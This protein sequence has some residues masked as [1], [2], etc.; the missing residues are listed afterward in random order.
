[1][2]TFPQCYLKICVG[3]V[4][5][6]PAG[7]ETYC[8]EGKTKQQQSIDLL[9]QGRPRR[10]LRNALQILPQN[11]P[12]SGLARCLLLENPVTVNDS[13]HKYLPS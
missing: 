9:T 8:R 6:R 13:L 1:M 11:D 4:F 5:P 2:L 10:C 7:V 12:D 3:S